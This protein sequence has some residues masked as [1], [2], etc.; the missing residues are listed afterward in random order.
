LYTSTYDTRTVKVAL[1]SRCTAANTCANARA[2]SPRSSN[3]RAPP[4]DMVYVLPAPVW[5]YAS[6]VP[7]TPRSTPSTTS[8]A[9]ARNTPA[10]ST[11]VPS[12]WSTRKQAPAPVVAFVTTL[13]DCKHSS[14]SVSQ[15]HQP[16]E[17]GG[18]TCSCA[19][20]TTALADSG[21]SG[22]SGRSLAGRMRTQTLTRPGAGPLSAIAVAVAIALVSSTPH[23]RQCPRLT[24]F[25]AEIARRQP[26]RRPLLEVELVSIYSPRAITS[27]RKLTCAPC[28]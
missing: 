9:A 11:P 28:A 4:P 12:T 19:F 18:C 14:Q 20:T 7:F 26:P 25:G 13:M 2:H 6:T 24:W 22:P 8:A 16:V 3:R 21:R 5:P 27:G 1:A 17:H 23:N 15:S 10:W